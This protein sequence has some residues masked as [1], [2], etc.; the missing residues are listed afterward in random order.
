MHLEYRAITREMASGRPIFGAFHLVAPVGADGRVRF[1]H[2]SGTLTV[3]AE[4]RQEGNH[5][6]VIKVL[7]S[8]SARRLMEGWVRVPQT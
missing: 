5:W 6:K 3:G 1:G 2:P 4:V 7:M 8:R